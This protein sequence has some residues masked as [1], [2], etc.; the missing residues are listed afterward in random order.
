MPSKS[1][2][3]D[4]SKW[5]EVRKLWKE[6]GICK[7]NKQADERCA[8]FWGQNK[9][10]KIAVQRKIQ[11]LSTIIQSKRLNN[12]IAKAFEKQARK[13][14][15]IASEA[16]MNILPTTQIE[17]NLPK[18]IIQENEYSLLEEDTTATTPKKTATYTKT[19][20]YA[21]RIGKT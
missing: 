21:N 16:S 6:S 7:S 5:A 3:Y 17:I 14:P 2:G 11:E 20:Y 1:C 13:T 4:G 12:P 8:L 9:L 18:E 19:R 10:D 15:N